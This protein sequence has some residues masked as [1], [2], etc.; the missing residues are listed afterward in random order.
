MDHNNDAYLEATLP[1][2]EHKNRYRSKLPC[3]ETAFGKP[4]SPYTHT[5]VWSPT[6]GRYR[7]YL[8]HTPASG[9]GDDYINA[10]HVHVR[11]AVTH[12]L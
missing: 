10:S 12:T 11:Y 5:M 2:N 4:N 8:P 7:V 6:G 9:V 1:I 3:E